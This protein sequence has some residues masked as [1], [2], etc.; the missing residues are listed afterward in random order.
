MNAFNPL[1]ISITHLSAIQLSILT[2]GQTNHQAYGCKSV[3]Q[4]PAALRQNSKATS[5]VKKIF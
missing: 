1:C 3:Y 2:V 5:L 4:E